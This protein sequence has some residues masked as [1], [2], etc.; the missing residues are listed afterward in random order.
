MSHHELDLA[1]KD[2]GVELE[3]FLTVAV[4]VEVGLNT[5][6]LLLVNTDSLAQIMLRASA[7]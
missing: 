2:F 1:F 4:E 3:G 6:D 7:V 5:H